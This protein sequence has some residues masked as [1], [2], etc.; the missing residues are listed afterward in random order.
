MPAAL[1]FPILL[2]I[3][4]PLAFLS[5]TATAGVMNRSVMVVPFLA[6][7][8][9]ITTILIRKFTPSPAVELKAM[10]TPEADTQP[11][12]PFRG[13]G[14]RFAIGMVGYAIVFALSA[15]IAALFQST[16]F[17]PQI[18]TRDIWLA[19]VPA[20][21]ALLGA[22]LS[23]RLGLSQMASMMGQMQTAFSQM[24]TGQA[25]AQP[26]DDT[27]TVEGEIIDPDDPRAS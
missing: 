4:G 1:L 20:L 18:R 9:T 5:A 24:Q 23:A 22:W 2:R 15:W 19:L 11:E 16:E 27:F 14:R 13:M 8:A 3:A 26:D 7:A 17:E 25:S 12:S 10:L 6:L 21:I